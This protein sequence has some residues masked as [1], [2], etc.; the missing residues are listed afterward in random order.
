MHNCQETGQQAP[1]TRKNHRKNPCLDIPR[2]SCP[3]ASDGGRRK[4]GIPPTRAQSSLQKNVDFQNPTGLGGLP[5]DGRESKS[6]GVRMQYGRM[7]QSIL[8]SSEPVLW[9]QIIQVGFLALSLITG[10]LWQVTYSQS[11]SDFPSV[12]KEVI[13]T[14]WCF[15]EVKMG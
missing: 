12:R 1:V 15:C 4:G 9:R 14:S 3:L 10:W 8:E 2:D 11:A 7:F 5:Q 6:L 13:P